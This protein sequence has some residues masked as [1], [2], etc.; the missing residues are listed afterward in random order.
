MGKTEKAD[1]LFRKWLSAEPEWGFGWIGWSDLYWLWN[2]SIE[3]DFKKAEKILKEG[4]TVPKV[5]DREHI[6]ERLSDL[7]KAKADNIRPT[8]HSSGAQKDAPA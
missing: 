6:L 2:L 4:L 8:L 7:K 1:S 3:K 5:N